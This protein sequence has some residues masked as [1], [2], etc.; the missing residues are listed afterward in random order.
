MAIK[1]KQGLTNYKTRSVA[2]PN[3]IFIGDA[4]PSSTTLEA[5]SYI[6]GDI[7]IDVTADVIYECHTAGSASASVW[8][9]IGAVAGNVT[10]GVASG[11]KVARGTHTMT[12]SADTIVTGLSTVVS[13][14]ANLDFSQVQ[15]TATE[16]MVVAEIGDQ[17][18]SPAAG[19]IILRG[20]KIS[21]GT[22]VAS[23]T[24]F[25]VVANWIAIG[26]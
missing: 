2:N 5:G 19:S 12:A 18:G 9:T 20:L 17:A 1:R 14:V 13:A 21:G 24:P 26:T 6:Q 16:A 15:P 8:R 11:Y 23:T 3:R 22:F 7:F 25:A 10:L 4:A